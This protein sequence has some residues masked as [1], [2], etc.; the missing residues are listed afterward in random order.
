[1]PKHILVTGGTGFLANTLITTLLARGHRVTTTV[2]TPAK[3]QALLA[4]YT[5]PAKENSLACKI[6]ADIAAPNAFDDA[7]VCDPPLSAVIHTASPFHYSIENA[8][9]DM[10]DPA[11]NGTVGILE[12]VYNHAPSVESVVITSSFAAMW[13]PTKPVGSKYSEADWNA[14]TWEEAELPENSKGQSGYRTSK[15]LAEKEAWKF[16]EKEPRPAFGLTVM[17]PSLIFGPVSESLASL[18]EVGTSCGRIRDFM[19]GV[20]RERCPP[21]G[22]AFWVDVRDAAMAHAL[23]VEN[24]ERTKGKRY[25]L[26]AG[27]F[28][29]RE[30]VEVIQRDFPELRDGLPSGEAL[31]DGEYPEGG[32]RYGFDNSAS[33]EDLGLPRYRS[34]EESVV[35]TVNSMRVIQQRTT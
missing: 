10:F 14:V 20:F 26:T 30:I 21:T 2:R 29:N 18:G 24:S 7:V 34:L 6:V 19:T 35:D 25:F 16:M 33:I 3:A 27:G 13:N 17:N 12:S 5:H 15:A 22:S 28:C 23:A 9:R 31:K 1:M 4:Q 11:V 8:K 32:P